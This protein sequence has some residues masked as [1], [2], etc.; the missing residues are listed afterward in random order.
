MNELLDLLYHTSPGRL[1]LRVLTRPG[2]SRLSGVLL[3]TRFSTALIPFFVRHARI[4]TQDYQLDNIR[5]FNDF[6]CRRIRDGL[7]PVETDPDRLIAPCDGLLRVWP[8]RDGL[9]LPVKESRY[10]V[11]SLLRSESLAAHYEGGLCLVFRLCVDH[12]HR[13]CYAES[14][15]KSRDYRIHGVLHTVQPVALAAGPVFAE[16]SRVFTLIRTAS[17]GTLLQMEVGAMLVGRITNLQ[18]DSADVTR[19]DEKGFFE[20]GGST[21]IVLVEPDRI[22]MDERFLQASR[23]GIEIPVRMGEAIAGRYKDTY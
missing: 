6:F 13:Y 12:Y 8:I 5:S 22:R 2:L 3:D 18:P 4:R 10:T 17:F 16:N 9:V 15:K 20:Y 19:G 21:I 7:R 11:A 23:D 1:I 14:G